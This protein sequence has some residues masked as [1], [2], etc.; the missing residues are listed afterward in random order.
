LSGLL[1]RRY[2]VPLYEVALKANA[3]DAVEG[4]LKQLD[5]ALAASPDLKRLLLSPSEPRA[6]KKRLLERLF[7]GASPYTLKFIGLVIDKKNP[8][9]LLAASRLYGDLLNAHRGIVTGTVE[10]AV[11]LGEAL[12]G[13][14]K[15][16]LGERFGGKLELEQRVDPG[17]L[18][19]VRVRVGN[20]VYDGSV[21]GRLDRIRAALAGQ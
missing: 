7:T 2:V 18:G 6:V 15:A 21:K 20:S 5:G 16:A 3:L 10:S 17:L 8:E 14:L 11:P 13:Q 4:D 1:T 19:G 9:V 12:F